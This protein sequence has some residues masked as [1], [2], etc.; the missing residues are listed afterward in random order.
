MT[1]SPHLVVDWDHESS[2]DEEDDFYSLAPEL[3]EFSSRASVAESSSSSAI[4][5]ERLDR[6]MIASAPNGLYDLT[7]RRTVKHKGSSETLASALELDEDAVLNHHD[8]M[9]P[10]LVQPLAYGVSAL[11][12]T[13]RL[14]LAVTGAVS[15][16][17]LSTVR[18]GTT[19]GIGIGR[20]IVVGAL[21]SARI[22]RSKDH[23]TEESMTS[24]EKITERTI[25]AA[26]D[27]FSLAELFTYGTWHLADSTVRF[28]ITAAT[29]TIQLL[30]GV[31]GS[32]ETSRAISS[33]VALIQDEMQRGIHAGLPHPVSPQH[34]TVLGTLGSI[35]TLGGVTKALTAFACLQAVTYR[36][37]LA[38]RRRVARVF[39]GVVE[40]VDPRAMRD[41]SLEWHR[42]AVA[43]DRGSGERWIQ[44]E[45]GVVTLEDA[46]VLVQE[47]RLQGRDVDVLE[48][49][50]GFLVRAKEKVGDLP[51]ESLFAVRSGSGGRGDAKF[52]DTVSG[53]FAGKDMQGLVK[54][55]ESSVAGSNEK[56]APEKKG[57]AWSFF[58]AIAGSSSVAVNPV[59]E[60]EDKTNNPNDSSKSGSS[61]G[62]FGRLKTDAAK[63]TKRV[64]KRQSVIMFD[65]RDSLQKSL[66]GSR[67]ERSGLRLTNGLMKQVE[68]H[69]FLTPTASPDGYLRYRNYPFPHLLQ[70]LDRYNRFSAAAYGAEFMKMMNMRH[71]HT[72][73][74]TT[75]TNHHAFSLHTGV[76]LPDILLSSF[77]DGE[78]APTAPS[79]DTVIHYVVLD[80]VARSVV[81]TLR[82]TFALNDVITD[83]KADYAD[84][85]GY[86]THSGMLR[87]AALLYKKGAAVRET[88][89]KALDDYPT[90]GIV[91]TGHSLGAGVAVLLA[92]RWSCPTSDLQI[93][94]DSPYHPPTPFVTSGRGGFPRG[95][96]IHCYAYGSPSI[97]SYELSV[98]CKGLVST[99]VNGDDIVPT[100]SL[101][102]V[103]DMKS[104]TMSLLDVQN[105]G[106]SE[107]IIW[108]TLGFNL[109][110]KTRG[111]ARAE[112]DARGEDYFWDVLTQLRGSMQNERLYVAGYAYLMVL[113]ETVVT[114]LL[115]KETKTTHRVTLE[116]CDDVREMSQEPRFSSR[117]LSDHMPPEYEATMA[118]LMRGV[119][120]EI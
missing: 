45:S 17:L 70:N 24:L 13:A 115:S 105:R 41:L 109:S 47:A 34:A 8:E 116:R 33:L 37:S 76:A 9:K 79:Y 82:G 29:E 113:A 102:L 107:R 51:A 25:Q 3:S 86:K 31:F 10:V 91:I 35:A 21:S 26:T 84:F 67:M 59:V 96:P 16:T 14:S 92:L 20:S 11:S 119:F 6:A 27:A 108:R 1:D 30:D 98:R 38:E 22:F 104:V 73:D 75:H 2:S 112:V 100:L 77:S 40:K 52:L 44:E 19:L 62:L 5:W 114:N 32:T 117:L 65:Q 74:R 94:P 61:F 88:V 7:P 97:V 12:Q 42:A 36:R 18:W 64:S 43:V 49:A 58:R 118:A 83:L 89:R 120:G 15:D 68:A 110:S 60:E 66:D 69:A 57:K 50:Q 63:K 103:R 85:M 23:T 78:A 99:V 56:G 111:E 93:H 4:D 28:S 90:Y 106:L 46:K 95:R 55:F 80:H 54:D 71:V 72:N 48:S 81:V 87:C 39:D 101:G 53:D